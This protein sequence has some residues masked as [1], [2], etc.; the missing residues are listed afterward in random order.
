MSDDLVAPGK[1]DFLKDMAT[2]TQQGMLMK[3]ISGSMALAV[4]L[5]VCLCLFPAVLAADSP[6]CTTIYTINLDGD[7]AAHWTIEYRTPLVQESD[8]RTFANYSRDMETRY[9]PE[10]E[11]LMNSSAAQAAAAT[12]RPMTVENFTGTTA[13]Q[14]TLSGK[15]GVVTISFTWTEFAARD[16]GLAAGDVFIGGMYLSKGDT[17]IIR[18]PPGYQQVSADPEPDRQDRDSSAWYGVRSFATGTPR[19]VLQENT[20]PVIPLLLGCC[21]VLIVITGY[22][23]FRRKK[24]EPEISG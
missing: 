7:G 20:L 9:L 23:A 16:N 18:Y 14:T 22:L 2:M 3:Q 11:N 8:A 19:V 21:I 6:D 12:S 24:S 4:F 15:S 13:I 17:L 1:Q 5:L 10:I